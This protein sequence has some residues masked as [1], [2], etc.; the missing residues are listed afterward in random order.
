MNAILVPLHSKSEIILRGIT[1]G[2]DSWCGMNHQNRSHSERSA[3]RAKAGRHG[4]EE[5]RGFSQNVRARSGVVQA[6]HGILHCASAHHQSPCR[7]SV[8]NDL[9]FWERFIGSKCRE[10]EGGAARSRRIPWNG[11]WTPGRH[12]CSHGM[13][14]LRSIPAFAHDGTALSMTAIFCTGESRAVIGKVHSQQDG[15]S[16]G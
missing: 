14:R 8:Q 1:R 3:A 16:I 10:G 15:E 5:S 4:V 7:R 13:L 9:V 2:R 12:R 11:R 6:F